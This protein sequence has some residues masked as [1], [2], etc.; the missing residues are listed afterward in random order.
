MSLALEESQL[1]LQAGEV[2]VGAV[3]LGPDGAVL[4]RSGNRCVSASD[5]SAHAEIMVLR[6]AAAA[7]G[8]YRL[9]GC[10]LAVTLEPCLM[11]VGAIVHARVAGVVWGVAD[12][13]AGAVQ[14]RMEGLELDFLNHRV[15]QAGGISG[16]ECCEIIKDFFRERR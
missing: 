9:G 4:G 12:P 16:A 13:V 14:S 15:W 7:L 6:Q 11:C 10:V 3:L 1:A 5:P 2:P 8:N